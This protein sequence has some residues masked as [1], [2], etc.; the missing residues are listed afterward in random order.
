ML[1]GDITHDLLD[2]ILDGDQAIGAAIFI[3]HQRQMGVAGLH[4]QKQI[5]RP[6]GWRGKQY[7]PHDARDAGIFQLVAVIL[8]RLQQRD[9]VLHMHQSCRIIQIFPVNRKAR[10]LRL[11][12]H[13]HQIGHAGAFFHRHD[14]GARHHHIGH[15][16]FA[17]GQKIAQHHP[18]L[19][20]QRQAL[21]VAFLDHFLQA[22]AHGGTVGIHAA[23][24]VHQ[25][26]EQS[27]FAHRAEAFADS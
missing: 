17:K 8:H 14:L 18:F 15:L 1:V 12:K 19:G 3:N 5:Q 4:F 23:Q 13:R 7:G 24:H 26:A 10:M 9:G 2:N 22:F 21:P 20:R 25:P 6:H 11:A 16:Q 27:G